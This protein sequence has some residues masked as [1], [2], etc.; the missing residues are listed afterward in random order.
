M[1]D[2]CISAIGKAHFFQA[3]DVKP[4]A[5]I[6]DVGFCVEN[7]KIYGDFDTQSCLDAGN[8]ITPVP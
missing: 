3:S 2:I 8:T 4:E 5:L 1:A 6:V 7:G